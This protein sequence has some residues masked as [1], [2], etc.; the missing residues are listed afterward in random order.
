MLLWTLPEHIKRNGF[1]YCRRQGSVVLPPLLPIPRSSPNPLLHVSDPTHP[2]H[3]R[4]T[5]RSVLHPLTVEVFG[6]IP[7][8]KPCA[9]QPQ[10]LRR[11]LVLTWVGDFDVL[12]G[13]IS[14]RYHHG[15][16]IAFDHGYYCRTDTQNDCHAFSGV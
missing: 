12:G 9:T 2:R 8:T 7:G 11:R 14:D 6:E 16:D 4:R 13:R 15:S 1:G 10:L 3:D 5:G